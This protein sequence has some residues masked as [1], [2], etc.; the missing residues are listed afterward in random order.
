MSIHYVTKKPK[1]ETQREV[2]LLLGTLF[3]RNT[4]CWELKTDVG[5]GVRLSP[6]RYTPKTE[7]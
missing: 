6:F 3:A 4:F 2:A 7:S 5:V 1:F